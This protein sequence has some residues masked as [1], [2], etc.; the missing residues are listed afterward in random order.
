VDQGV[1]HSPGRL[2]VL[3]CFPDL[4]ACIPILKQLHQ[5]TKMSNTNKIIQLQ[6][7][8]QLT[9]PKSRAF[10]CLDKLETREEPKLL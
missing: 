3:S 5:S 6:I 7:L 1:L 8:L 4:S 10:F 2:L 9:I